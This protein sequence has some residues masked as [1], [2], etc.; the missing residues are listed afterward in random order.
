M[1]LY[2]PETEVL[3]SSIQADAQLGRPLGKQAR[4]P[5][6]RALMAQPFALEKR[7]GPSWPPG[8]SRPRG[9]S[10]GRADWP[11][12]DRRGQSLEQES[13]VPSLASQPGTGAQ[14]GLL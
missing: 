6:G 14:V 3:P 4:S 1:A 2:D 9:F 7:C 11:D 12:Q 10:T 5:A 13:W 8:P